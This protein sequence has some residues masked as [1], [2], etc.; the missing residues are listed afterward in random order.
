[1]LRIM[2][3][4]I[5][6]VTEDI[7]KFH[8]NTAIAALMEYVNTLRVQFP[9]SKS[10]F[11]KRRKT[12]KPVNQLTNIQQ[13]ALKTLVLLMAPFAPHLAEEIWVEVL[14]EKFSVHRAPW[15]KYNTNYIKVEHVEIVVQVNGKL[16][17]TLKVTSNMSQVKDEV[18]KLAKSDEKV[19][20]WISGK[21]IKKEIFVPGKLVNV[22][23]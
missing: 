9:I 11:P 22:V 8:Y 23:V 10:Q 15:P 2:H 20:K 17:S 7:E 6:K 21:K 12:N 5:K 16:R 1:M 18:V 14:R 19:K 4:T 3:Q 13:E